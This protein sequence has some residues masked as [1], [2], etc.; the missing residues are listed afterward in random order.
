MSHRPIHIALVMDHPAQQ[1]AHA[2]QV[3]AVEPGVRLDVYYW[4]VAKCFYDPGFERS[5]SWDID[6]LGDYPWTT[7]PAHRSVAS[8]L[9]WMAGKLHT[10]RPDVV[11]C[12][13]WASPVARASIIYCAV[14]R[15]RLLLYGDTTW[16]HASRGRH[17]LGKVV[18]PAPANAALRRGP[19]DRGFQPRVLYPLWHESAAYLAR[20]MPC[21]H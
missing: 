11:V 7:S 19:F 18:G 5:V 4:S 9:C 1:F 21:R 2:L 13:G 15:T 12:Y 8:R 14:S 10:S 6:L 16:Q 17:R 3:L 20:C